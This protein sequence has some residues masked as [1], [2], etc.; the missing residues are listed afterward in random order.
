[1]NIFDRLRRAVDEIC[2]SAEARHGEIVDLCRELRED[3]DIYER[4][5]RCRGVGE[6]GK[7]KGGGR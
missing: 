6:V 1:M 5:S 7:T 2:S 3:I 4:L